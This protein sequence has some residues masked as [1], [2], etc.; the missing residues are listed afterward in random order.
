MTFELATMT[1]A[2][3][4]DVRTLASKDRKPDELRD[5]DFVRAFWLFDVNDRS[6]AWQT[7]VE[8]LAA[9]A[10]PTRV[11][12]LAAKW[13]CDANDAPMYAKHVGATIQM[14]GSAWFATRADFINL[15]ESP[16]GFGDTPVE[17]FAELAKELGYR[18]SKM[19]GNTF[20]GLLKAKVAPT[21]AVGASAPL[22]NPAPDG[23]E[24]AKA[25]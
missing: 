14:D 24:N 16:A 9:G 13:G 8:G 17:T 23:G 4:L 2:R 3:V 20:A 6:G 19:W 10:N 21:S 25:G 18:P 12:E 15:Q 11:K 7:C 5:S 1:K 22:N